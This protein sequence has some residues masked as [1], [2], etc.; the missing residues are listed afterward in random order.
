MKQSLVNQINSIKYQQA[1]SSGTNSKN[2]G[3]AGLLIQGEQA[4][5]NAPQSLKDS[6]ISIKDQ[7]VINELFNVINDDSG[8]M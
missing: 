3:K 7:K 8:V 1:Q 2:K 5:E 6:N 4:L